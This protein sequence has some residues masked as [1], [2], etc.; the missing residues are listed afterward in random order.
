VLNVIMLSVI[1][2]LYRYTGCHF[3]ECCYYQHHYRELHYAVCHCDEVLVLNAI[4]PSVIT[5]LYR[6]TGCHFAE[7]CYYQCHYREHHYAVCHWDKALI[8]NIIMPSVFTL[9]MHWV[10]I[11][12]I[13]FLPASLQRA[14]LCCVS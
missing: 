2:L 11:S 7:C 6:Y 12:R 13:L 5:L 14:S 1:T 8:L 3:A 4:L 9:C 10:T